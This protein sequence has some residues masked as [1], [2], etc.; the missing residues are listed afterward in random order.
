[1]ANRFISLNPYDPKAV[2]GSILNLVDANFVDSDP[3]KAQRQLYGYSVA[4]K[5]YVLYE[6]PSKS[7]IRIID[8][9]VPKAHGIGFLYPP[10]N[11]DKGWDSDAP[12]GFTKCGNTLSEVH[13]V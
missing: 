9:K 6:K 8:P 12:N 2:K 5:R 11:S 7:E 10:K 3:N 1:M 13:F 4:S